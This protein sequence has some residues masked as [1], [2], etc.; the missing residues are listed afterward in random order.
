MSWINPQLMSFCQKTINRVISSFSLII[1]I[2][3]VI[4]GS[5][6]ARQFS[7]STINH[8]VFNC[9]KRPY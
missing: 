8:R 4:Y 2:N 6:I 9:K 7:F 3:R 1:R 5:A